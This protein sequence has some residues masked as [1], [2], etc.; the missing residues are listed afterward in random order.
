MSGKD[1]YILQC[2]K[3][4]SLYENEL[5]NIHLALDGELMVEY[6]KILDYEIWLIKEIEDD[7][8]RSIF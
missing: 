8:E 7:L 2:R 3:I 1:E 5:E 4:L 6:K